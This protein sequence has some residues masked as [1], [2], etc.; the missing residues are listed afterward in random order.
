MIQLLMRI[1]PVIRSRFGLHSLSPCC[2]HDAFLPSMGLL[3]LYHDRLSG[4]GQSS[5]ANIC[6]TKIEKCCFIRLLQV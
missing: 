4:L 3:L 2:I 5:E 1:V 6:T